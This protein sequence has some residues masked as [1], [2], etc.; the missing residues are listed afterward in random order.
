MTTRTDYRVT[1]LL[2]LAFVVL[3]AAGNLWLASAFDFPDILRQPAAER[4]ARFQANQGGI[5]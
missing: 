4:F 5:I 3:I 2:F 1:A